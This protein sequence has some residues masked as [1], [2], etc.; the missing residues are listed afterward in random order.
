MSETRGL[1]A[2]AFA[3]AMIVAVWV[4][5]LSACG[6][7][8]PFTAIE[9]PIHVEE[10]ASGDFLYRCDEDG[11]GLTHEESAQG[12]IAVGVR[13][14]SELGT[15]GLAGTVTGDTEG[16]TASGQICFGGFCFIEGELEFGETP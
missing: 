5:C 8:I 1:T 4:T 2:S 12:S 16:A 13:L 10:G 6:A 15:L 3:I 11:C 7:A 14:E 9:V